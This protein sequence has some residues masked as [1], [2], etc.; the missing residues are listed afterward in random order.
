MTE[1]SLE[2]VEA[3]V[4]VVLAGFAVGSRR[5]EPE[6]W[7]FQGRLFAFKHAEALADGIREVRLAPGTVVTP[8]ARDH[9]KRMGVAVRLVAEA[10]VVGEG[11][12]GEWGFA[13]D[14]QSGTMAALRR[15]LLAEEGTWFD[16]GPEPSRA[17]RWVAES[18]ARGAVALTAESSTACWQANQVRGIRAAT[19]ADA[20]SV[21]RAV[22]HL[23]A[24]LLVIEPSGKSIPWLK[25][26]LA[27]YRKAGAPTPPTWLGGGPHNSGLADYAD[28][29]GDRPSDALAIP[30]QPPQ[31]EV[32]AGRAYDGLGTGRG[33]AD[34]W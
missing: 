23:G 10:E 11:R 24:N 5:Q 2:Q 17:A 22:R 3:A 4:R 25:Q 12:R 16:V 1:P 13:I 21:A 20:D 27:V 26:M 7:N 6:R 14:D 31:C 28:C 29:P 34:P 30:L 15:G 33:R 8:M 18:P 9:L 32:R 19:V